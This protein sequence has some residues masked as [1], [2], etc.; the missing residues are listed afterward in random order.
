MN[1]GGRL[2]ACRIFSPSHNKILLG[3]CTQISRFCAALQ[4]DTIACANGTDGGAAG[5]AA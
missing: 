3:R 1:A 5:T 4:R 2:R